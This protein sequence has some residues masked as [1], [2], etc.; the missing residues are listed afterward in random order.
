MFPLKQPF[1]RSG[2]T[3]TMRSNSNYLFFAIAGLHDRFTGNPR[4]NLVII[5]HID[6]WIHYELK[7]EQSTG[8]DMLAPNV[9]DKSRGR[10]RT[11]CKQVD[12][13][14]KASLM[15]QCR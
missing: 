14:E 10:L 4:R 2:F 5:N 8:M 12:F 6:C 3:K 9:S 15:N 1:Y 7:T 13:T 11:T